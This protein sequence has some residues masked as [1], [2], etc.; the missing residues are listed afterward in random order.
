VQKENSTSPEIGTTSVT[1]FSSVNALVLGPKCASCHSTPNLRGGIDLSNYET[2][3]RSA[4]RIQARAIKDRTMP[5]DNSLSSS[6]IELLDKWLRAGAPLSAQTVG[7]EP[8]QSPV[9]V[10]TWTD[11]KMKFFVSSCYTCHSPPAPDGNL[12]LTS[13]TDVRANASKI[14]N[15]VVIDQ[16]MPIAPIAKPTPE[17]K[18]LLVDWLVGG[19]K[20]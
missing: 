2:V 4:G 16:T 19:M 18:K 14:F 17:E 15:R 6:E 10:P 1:D 3:K 7:K 11:V 13:L 12:D 5:P 20:E 8:D 9:Q